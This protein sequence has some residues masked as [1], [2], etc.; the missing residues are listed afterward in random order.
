MT[1]IQADLFLFLAALIWG[2]TFLFQKNVM[3]IL[4]PLTFVSSRFFLS[5][6]LLLPFALWELR[7]IKAI[8]AV[9]PEASGQRLQRCRP[10]G[11]T[12]LGV[13]ILGLVFSL[14]VILQQI[15][16]D[17]TTITNTGFLTELH[18]VFTPL[19]VWVL[20]REVPS[21]TVWIAAVCSLAGVWLMGDASYSRLSTGDWIVLLCAVFYAVHT[22]WVGKMAQATHRPMMLAFWQYLICA[23]MAG[24]GAFA[25]ETVLLSNLIEALPEI[26]FAGIVSG[27]IAFT[28]Q[29]VAQQHTPPSHAAIILSLEALFGALIGVFIVGEELSWLAWSGCGILMAGVLLVELVPLRHRKSKQVP[30][31]H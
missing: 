24:I 22:T 14:A 30:V 13:F 8:K 19:F 7:R 20:V 12:A 28:L 18:V 6:F 9:H 1:R 3:E 11:R 21:G 23:I 5:A 16:L 17:G 15:G 10:S 31:V 25:F 29:I 4:D 27:G 26:L 2:V